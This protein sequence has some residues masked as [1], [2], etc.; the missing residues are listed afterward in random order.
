VI[1]ISLTMA[2][3]LYMILLGLIVLA[4]YLYTELSVRK[5]QQYLGE[6]FLWKCTFCACTYLDESANP[7]S[8]CP[9]C[10]SFN[11]LEDNQG[12]QNIPVITPPEPQMRADL[13]GGSKR[14]RHG[15]RR[16]P[17]RRR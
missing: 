17:R 3:A 5:P 14:K 2:L 10:N 8:Q 9:R 13:K 15:K 1:E 12:P 7:I 16:G 4:I 6:Q 11:S